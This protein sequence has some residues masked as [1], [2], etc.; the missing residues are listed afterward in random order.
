MN[1]IFRINQGWTLIVLTLILL[2][3]TCLQAR[4]SIVTRNFPIVNQ[5]RSYSILLLRAFS[6]LTG[7]SLWAT[8]STT[9]ERLK[10]V[11]ICRKGQSRAKFVEFLALQE[12]TSILGLLSLATGGAVPSFKT[13]LWSITRLLFI[14]FIPGIGIL[15]MSQVDIQLAFSPVSFRKPYFGYANQ[16]MNA[17]VASEYT[18][19]SDLLLSWK[20]SSFLGDPAR[21]I[22]LTPEAE[23]AKVCGLN[24]D[25][26]DQSGCHRTYFLSGESMFIMPELVVDASFPD[27]N[28]VLVRNHRGYLLD[29]NTG[30][31]TTE[32]DAAQECRTYSSRYLGAQ[33]GAI[34]LCVSNSSSNE[35]EARLVTCPGP[36][37]SRLM[38]LNDTSWFHNVDWTVKMSAFFQNSTVAYSRTN[39][40]ILWHSFTDGPRIPVDLSALQILEAYDHLLL[41]TTTLLHKNGTDLP[42]FSGSTFP[43][44]LWMSM[45]NFS[46][47]HAINP[48]TSS[49]VFSALQSLLAIPLYYC[50]TGMAR[51]LVPTSLD[52]KSVSNPDLSALLEVL[53]PLPER[54]SP[55]S[56]AYHR[57]E[58]VVGSPTLVAYIVLSGAALLACSIAQFFISMSARRTGRGIRMPHLSRYPALDLFT[59]CTIEDENGCAIYQGRS[60]AQP[61]DGS[62]GSLLSWLSTMSIKWSRPPSIQEDLQLF[63]VHRAD[64]PVDWPLESIPSIHSYS[65]GKLAQAPSAYI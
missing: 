51:R 45:P 48:A 6:E 2:V 54:S 58:I 7:L 19:F 34:R 49:G 25:A 29:F 26:L 40:T 5:S 38:C 22:D 32:F 62:Q 63:A 44:Y 8:I 65:S 50:Q 39:A 41:D 61:C 1:G 64:E 56:F 23:R 21:S 24:A 20:F 31:S 17:S 16:P 28:I 36:I 18:G 60:D 12:G 46:G 33:A 14:V 9:L 4:R 13:R 15:I 57:Y 27:A 52:G 59:H 37:A 35:L 42:L 55:T 43:T 3:I 30:D 10:W 53:S 11:M 47:Q